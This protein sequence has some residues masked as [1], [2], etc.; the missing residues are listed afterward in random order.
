MDPYVYLDDYLEVENHSWECDYFIAGSIE[1]E[2]LNRDD[3]AASI[4][5]GLNQIPYAGV[6]DSL[7][8]ELSKGWQNVSNSGGAQHKCTLEKVGGAREALFTKFQ[9]KFHLHY[10]QILDD[11]DDFY[12]ILSKE[13]WTLERKLMRGFSKSEAR[14]NI[15]MW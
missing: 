10:H 5:D 7:I 13:D 15:K 1:A 2:S 12:I 8:H 11:V 4:G 9:K 14:R 3:K 6:D